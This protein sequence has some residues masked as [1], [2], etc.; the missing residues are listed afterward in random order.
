MSLCRFSIGARSCLLATRRSSSALARGRV[1]AIRDGKPLGTW[2][3]RFTNRYSRANTNSSKEDKKDESVS[4][5]G[6]TDNGNGKEND[7]EPPIDIDALKKTLLDKDELLAKKDAELNE[8]ED[9]Y[10]RALA[11]TENTRHRMLKQVQDAKLFGIQD[12]TKDIISIA[13]VLE[14]A[15]ESVP[16]TQIEG[17]EANQSIVSLYNGLKMME[18][19]LLKVFSKHGLS[20]IE[21]GD[22]EKFDPNLHEAL[23]QIPGD[24]V[25]TIGA[26]SKVGYVLNGRTIRPAMVGVVK[27]KD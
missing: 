5:E 27:E 23:F 18:T 2:I 20:K 21:P 24:K 15:I 16:S 13:D 10:K 14:K 19:N 11:E 4:N 22:G 25:G 9:K 7:L 6:T 17:K 8:L 26:V 3:N 1:T 12:F